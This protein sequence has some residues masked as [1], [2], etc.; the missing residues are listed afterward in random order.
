MMKQDVIILGGGP[1]GLAAALALGSSALPS[2]L[3]VMLL[4]ARNPS[5]SPEDSRGTA[6][7]A[8]TQN[9]F[10]MIGV[11]TE[12]EQHAAPMRDVLVTDSQGAHA[13]RPAPLTLRSDSD[14]Q[15]PAVMVENAKLAAALLNMIAQSPAITL[16]GGFAFSHFERG[17]AKV[18]LYA[19]D[20]ASHAAPLL[21]AADGRNSSVR[22]QCHIAVSTED[23]GQ[24]AL[25]FAVRHTA[26]HHNMAEEHFSPDGVFA[27]LPLAG[28]NSSIVW[29]TSPAEAARLME[30][31]EVA[32][33]REL[34]ARMGERLGDVKLQG[35]RAAYPLSRTIAQELVADRVALLGDAAHAIHPLAGLGL[36]LG[37]K[38]AAALADCLAQA[39][40]RGE[41]IGSA[42][43]LERYQVMRRFDALATSLAMDGLNSV[44]VNNNPLLK[45]T[46]G[47]GL[48]VIDQLPQLKSWLLS[49]AAG[50]S[51][52]NPRLMQ[53]LMPG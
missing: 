14:Q 51:Q 43:V 40:R 28:D 32:F 18:T 13:L 1:N 7:T 8:A 12:L 6:L 38:D 29:G 50:L 47:A 33:N 53:G 2:P 39:T 46:R 27:V 42:S 30:L 25:S 44:F 4:D 19:S 16:Q 34:Q 52:N 48:K 23:Y 35:R 3:Q 21:I 31:D 11:W 49:E 36:N 24:T 10:R 20:G 37:F 26:P 15:A 17:S 22:R 41:D 45:A 5:T 9:M